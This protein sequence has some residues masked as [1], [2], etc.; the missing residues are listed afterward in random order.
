MASYNGINAIPNA[1]NSDL[2]QLLLREQLKFNGF[3]I[4]DYDEIGKLAGQY[5]PTSYLKMSD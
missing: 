3:V 4:S 1:M 2:L 5:M